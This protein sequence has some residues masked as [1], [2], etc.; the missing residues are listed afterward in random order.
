M[1][2]FNTLA[3]TLLI[4][5]GLFAVEHHIRIENND[6][7]FVYAVCE[8]AHNELNGSSEQACGDAQTKTDTEFLCTANTVGAGQCWVEAK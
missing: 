2:N 1:N 8:S 6:R 3:L 4:I 5:V 7:A